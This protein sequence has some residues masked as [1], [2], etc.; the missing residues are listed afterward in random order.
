GR[1]AGSGAR[2][3]LRL[4]FVVTA[5]HSNRA[6]RRRPPSGHRHLLLGHQP[7]GAT[8][9]TDRLVA[10]Q[11]QRG[12]NGLTES[13]RHGQWPRRPFAMKASGR[14]ALNSALACTK[15]RLAWRS[16]SACWGVSRPGGAAPRAGATTRTN[17]AASRVWRT[18][19]P[20]VIPRY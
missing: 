13:A 14:P 11:R 2:A 9:R 16:S 17:E 20:P 7:P 15:K 4:G 6:A 5:H 19:G 8:P 1:R 3:F 18:G 10:G 12:P